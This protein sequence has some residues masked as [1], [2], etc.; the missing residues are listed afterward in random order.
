MTAVFHHCPACKKKGVHLKLG[1]E[2]W[3]LCKYCED[4]AMCNEG[5]D[6]TDCVLRVEL[7]AANPDTLYG[8]DSGGV[9]R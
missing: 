8:W 3:W 1:K 2:D 5:N 4:W 6:E 7:A 9:Y